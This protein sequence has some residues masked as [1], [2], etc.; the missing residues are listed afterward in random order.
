M[1]APPDAGLLSASDTAIQRASLCPPLLLLQLLLL[2]T[3]LTLLL[4]TWR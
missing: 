4:M 1:L 2:L 3:L